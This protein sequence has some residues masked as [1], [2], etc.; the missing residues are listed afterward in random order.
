[1]EPDGILKGSYAKVRMT[2][3]MTAAHSS[4]FTISQNSPK[5]PEALRDDMRTSSLHGT[6][7]CKELG[8]ERRLAR[9]RGIKPAG[10]AKVK[11]LARFARWSF[12]APFQGLGTAQMG[13]AQAGLAE[14]TTIAWAC[15]K[16]SV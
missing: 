13:W 6:W 11:K 5:A 14:M 12:H 1:M 8:R 9:P 4:V 7:R 15:G 3:A 16:S 10:A 2:T